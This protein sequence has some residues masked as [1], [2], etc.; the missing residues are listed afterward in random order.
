MAK[1]ENPDTHQVHI[2]LP[3]GLYAI[4]AE[5][6]RTHAVNVNTVIKLLLADAVGWSAEPPKRDKRR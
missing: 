4:L 2:R 6:A 3:E 1:Q 5:R